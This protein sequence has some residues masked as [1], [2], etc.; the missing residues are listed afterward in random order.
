MDCTHF[1]RVVFQYTDNE[2]GE[3]QLVEFHQHRDLC[4]HCERQLALALALKMAL[5]E[6]CR[7]A[8][9]PRSLRIRILTSLPHRTPKR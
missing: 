6:R 8:V 5:R 4:R 2:L 3:T 9:A 7:R 1:Q